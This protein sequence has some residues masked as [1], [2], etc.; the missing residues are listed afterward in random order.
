MYYS[1]LL[2]SVECA[3]WV[4]S[5]DSVVTIKANVGSTKWV[6]LINECNIDTYTALEI[7]AHLI[8]DKSTIIII[9]LQ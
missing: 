6:G 2:T 3:V 9:F 1:L 4:I 5:S 7:C 8:I